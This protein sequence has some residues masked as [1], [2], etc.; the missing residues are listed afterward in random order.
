MACY[1]ARIQALCPFILT[2]ALAVIGSVPKHIRASLACQQRNR[3][4]FGWLLFSWI[5]DPGSWSLR[6]LKLR[7]FNTLGLNYIQGVCT[8]CKGM[9]NVLFAF[10]YLL[11][12]CAAHLIYIAS[13]GE[14]H[15]I[16]N[17]FPLR[18]W[19]Q[20]PHFSVS[21]PGDLKIPQKELRLH[22]FLKRSCIIEVHAFVY[23]KSHMAERWNIG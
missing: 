17:I 11:N 13:C 23:A 19:K 7:R 1:I 4:L 14:K 22:L 3:G 8:I 9:E 6:V 10:I 16:S 12:L 15:L 2:M 5:G 20:G 18:L 21:T